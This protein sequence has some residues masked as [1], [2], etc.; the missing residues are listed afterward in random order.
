MF[1]LQK[2][3]T[4]CVS[5]RVVPKCAQIGIIQ[6][7]AESQIV[8][9]SVTN[10]IFIH[11]SEISLNINEKI[12]ALSLAR[13]DTSY[14]VIIVG[15]AN[16]VLVHDVYKNVDL[17]RRELPDGV[18]C[19][20][21][22]EFAN[23]GKIIMCGSN[24]AL[25]GFDPRGKDIFWTVT[26]ANINAICFTDIDGDGSYE[27]V[28]GTDDYEIRIFKEDLLL[29]ELNETDEISCLCD[30][31]NGRFA[32]GLVN[33]TL[34]VYEGE[35]RIWRIKTKN[36]PEALTLFPDLNS[37]VCAWS[38]GKIDIRRVEDGEARCK[39]AQQGAVAN[40]F[41]SGTTLFLVTVDGFVHGYQVSTDL[42]Q[43]EDTTSATQELDLQKRNLLKGKTCEFKA[44]F[45]EDTT[46]DAKMKVN[47]QMV[48]PGVELK[49]SISNDAIIRAVVIFGE[50]I[51]EGESHI[52]HV[53]SNFSQ[54]VCIILTP[55]KDVAVLL[56]IKVFVGYPESKQ[57]HIFEISRLLP[58]FSMYATCSENAPKPIGYTTFQISEKPNR[59]AL[60]I[61]ENF[62]LTDEF[63]C[64]G[65]SN[66]LS[67]NFYSIR[68]KQMIVI[69]MDVDGTITIRCNDM[70]V[71]G[72]II[73]SIAGYFDINTLASRANFPTEM[74]TLNDLTENLNEMYSLQ[75]QLSASMAERIS[76]VKELLVRAEDARNI[77]QT[78]MMKRYY[79]KLQMTNQGIMTEHKVRCNNYDQLLHDLRLLNNT[80][81]KSARL[82]VGD[83]A[84]K[85]ISL[86][87]E[88][89]SNENF[90]MLSKI[91][92]F[93]V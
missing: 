43:L 61:N 1:G 91:M 59:L 53:T 39:E 28:V 57:L 27:V 49:I 56:L 9:A 26:G 3:S 70:E 85:I 63:I 12:T 67:V 20:E 58:K 55:E 11:D 82:R 78:N 22:S 44:E 35:T 45:Q 25:W 4:Y 46:V 15:T 52:V 18:R 74:K 13:F 89:I 29:H 83:P 92:F 40:L 65:N 42:T 8:T 41:V 37:L 2:V 16:G 5:N 48:P 62:L 93:G 80:I 6:S 69:E 10:K 73:Q 66:K 31:G 38:G 60:W 23:C 68:L 17:F 72:N 88:A 90:E 34:G 7:N 76:L 36:K 75:D 87:R 33:G 86:C 14:D 77:Q 51:F 21:V 71:V 81:E 79:V 30:L 32:Y 24:C 19:L 47:C 64:N 54:E 50:G 84:R